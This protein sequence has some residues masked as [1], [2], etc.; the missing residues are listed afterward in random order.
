MC[1]LDHGPNH[2]PRRPTRGLPNKDCLTTH[3]F[4]PPM[5]PPPRVWFCSCSWV[6]SPC[7]SCVP[8]VFSCGA[9]AESREADFARNLLSVTSRFVS[10]H[11]VLSR[12]LELRRDTEAVISGLLS[13]ARRPQI[14]QS[15]LGV[16]RYVASIPLSLHSPPPKAPMR[17]MPFGRLKS[18]TIS[19]RTRTLRRRYGPSLRIFYALGTPHFP[20]LN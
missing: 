18:P 4:K 7:F 3:S 10:T 20:E 2:P 19:S 6:G 13:P 14:R 11:E 9:W 8:G 15:C 16:F 1:R 12:A 5:P 17:C